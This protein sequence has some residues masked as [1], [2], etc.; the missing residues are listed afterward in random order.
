MTIVIPFA[1]IVGLIRLLNQLA[2]LIRG[3]VPGGHIKILFYY[4][5]N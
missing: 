5:V 2:K 4:E 1:E 3:M